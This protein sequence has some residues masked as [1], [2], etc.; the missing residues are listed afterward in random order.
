MKRKIEYATAIFLLV[1]L[2]F[3]C[4]SDLTVGTQKANR[5]PEVW[6]AIGPP[7]GSVTDYRV[8]VYWGGWDPDGQVS[9]FEWSLTDNKTGVFDPADTTG[10]D[11]WHRTDETDSV[12]IVT[13]D[14]LAD[15]STLDNRGPYE[16]RRGH[17]FFVRAVDDNG[18][19]STVPVYRSFTSKTIAPE[20]FVTTPQRTGLNS[21]TMPP[22]IT[23]EWL[24]IDTDS[25]T[26]A[27][28]SARFI[29]LP[30]I[31]FMGDWDA[32]STYIRENPDAPEWSN[33]RHY[34]SDSGKSWT[35]EEALGFGSYI[36][37]A[38][39]MDEAGAVTP[40]FDLRDNVRRL[41]VDRIASGPVVD[42]QYRFMNNFSTASPTT[43]PVILDLPAG[44]PIGFSWGADA[45]SY[46]GT[47]T[48]YRYG[49]DI[50]DLND[51]EQWEIDFTPFVGR[52][53]ISPTRL[54]FFG[55][56]TFFLEVIDNNGLLTRITIVI[57]IV[58]FTMERSL[59]IVDDWQEDGRG[60][61]ASGG[62]EPSDREHDVFWE[63]MVNDVAGFAP[64]RDVFHMEGGSNELPIHILAKYQCVIWNAMG[65]AVV[66]TGSILNQYIKFVHPSSQSNS[67]NTGLLPN[68]LRMFME[69]GGK[70]F[71]C[72]Q[73]IMTTTINRD[74]MRSTRYPL[75]FRYEITG[76][77]SGFY[78]DSQVGVSGIGDTSFAYDDYCLNVLD[79]S[80][81]TNPNGLR[82][83]PAD[84]SVDRI[85][86]RNARTD[87]L[88][89]CI[90]ADDT[91]A[92]PSLSLRPEV[93]SAGRWYHESRLGLKTDIYNPPYFAG[94]CNRLSEQNPPRG[95]FQTIYGLGCLN[96]SSVIYGAPIAYWTSTHAGRVPPVGVPARSVVWGFEPVYF[97]PSEVKDAIEIILFDEWKLPRQ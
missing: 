12:F 87:G 1:V 36:F 27:P 64:G 81:S 88:R 57:N 96:T 66:E 67:N 78:F 15:S 58:P 24:A 18:A 4:T 31:Q 41:L 54:F 32:A 73:H 45:S 21:A 85:R 6:L 83:T 80:F 29:L 8:H 53:A 30:M 62:L 49:W 17:T 74:I 40:V 20:I 23:F 9:Y 2:V 37:A 34:P 22:V 77:Q 55:T 94:L 16:F 90:P 82:R 70:T 33:W 28:D 97:N 19:S 76:N 75:I 43:A 86:D 48:G 92:F 25:D 7:E 60:L 84:C 39:A 35:T 61:W 56:H 52:R 38:Q 42:I 46:G 14:V 89:E 5:A 26:Q 79:I 59:L 47:V 91:Y 65:S 68:I 11:K 44:L 50:L 51:P 71:L 63:Q 10:A 72:G 95:C 13:A 3:G 93:A 69:V